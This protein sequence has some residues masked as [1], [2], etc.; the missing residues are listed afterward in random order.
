[1]E[2]RKSVLEW[3]EVAH[4]EAL[5]EFA[6][7]NMTS[8]A[9]IWEK[10]LEKYP[11][12]MHALKMAHDTYFYLG[13][14][15]EMKS[16]LERVIPAYKTD[17]PLSE[18]LHGM[19]AFGLEESKQYGAAEK[20][21]KTGL[22][23]QPYDA[24]ATH[25]LAHVYEMGTKTLDGLKF[26]SSTVKNWDRCNFLAC[27]NFWHWALFHIEHSEPDGAMDLLETE[28]LSRATSSGAMLDV[29]DAASLLYRL[30]LLHPGEKFTTPEWWTKMT[31]TVEGHF[32]D[33]ILGFN[34]AH[35]AMLCLG[36]DREN[37]AEKLLESLREVKAN[38][39]DDW[40][41]TTEDL[42]LALIDFKRERYAE[43]VERLLRIRANI[44]KIGGSDAQRDVFNHLLIVGAIRSKN[45]ELCQTLLTERQN[46]KGKDL[47]VRRLETFLTQES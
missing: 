15:S 18:Y 5:N 45:S 14:S 20:E 35:F 30:E 12:D 27:H 1:M 2:N 36:T 19:Y 21:A 29:V 24:W 40:V 25:A 33:N 23:K 3:R 47:P 37:D 17:I 16:S 6:N 22:E 8:A 39:H 38:I 43:S 11:T 9:K 4:V 44:Y 31:D 41:S 42:L 13:N 7:A 34:Q 28:I 26:L 46:F 10:I 32:G